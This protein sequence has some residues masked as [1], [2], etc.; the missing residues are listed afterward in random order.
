MIDVWSDIW[1]NPSGNVREKIWS[2]LPHEAQASLVHMKVTMQVVDQTL[3]IRNHVEAAHI[4]D[5][6]HP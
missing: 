1:Y 6:E 5:S 4:A 2:Q 3:T